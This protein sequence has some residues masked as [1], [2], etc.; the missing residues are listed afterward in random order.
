MNSYRGYIVHNYKL[1]DRKRYLNSRLGRA[2]KFSF[3]EI[4]NIQPNYVNERYCGVNEKSWNKKSK[5]LWVPAPAPRQLTF[6]EIACTASH[7][8]IY[9]QYLR[10]GKEGWVV[11]L[12]DDAIFECDLTEEISGILKEVPD[13]VD[14]IFIGGGYHHDAVSL[15]VGGYKNFI[16]KH[17]PATNTAVGYM[18]RKSIV[19]AIMEDFTNFDMPIDFELAYLLMIKNALVMHL[20]PY[21]ISEGSKFHY[22]SSISR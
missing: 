22:Q 16:I 11:V 3:I 8:Y 5:N 10:N 1:V 2:N 14:A 19:E 4:E 6:G 7:F 18:L 21:L 15:T 12:E 17:H 20:N 9:E 13:R